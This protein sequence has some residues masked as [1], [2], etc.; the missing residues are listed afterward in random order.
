MITSHQF[1]RCDGNPRNDTQASLNEF[2]RVLMRVAY[3][4]STREVSEHALLVRFRKLAEQALDN[5]QWRL[6]R[7]S[8]LPA[9]RRRIAR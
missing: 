5:H 4:T 1:P 2:E 9:E 3:Q 6:A 8:G 7:A